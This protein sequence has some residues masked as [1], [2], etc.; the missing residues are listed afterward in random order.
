MHAFRFHALLTGRLTHLKDI[1]HSKDALISH[2]AS[3]VSQGMA[4]LSPEER[5]RTYK[6]MCLHVF[7]DRGG[8]LTAEWGCNDATTPQCSSKSTTQTFRFRALLIG[9]DTK[10]ELARIRAVGSLSQLQILSNYG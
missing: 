5:N 10:L 6:M 2:Y 1:E 4:E 7:A 8:A 9:K 3:L